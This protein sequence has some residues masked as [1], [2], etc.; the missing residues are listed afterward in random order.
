[1]V[2]INKTMKIIPTLQQGALNMS[3]KALVVT[4][5]SSWLE[6]GLIAA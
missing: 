6:P 4:M 3:F 2:T 1:M 5:P